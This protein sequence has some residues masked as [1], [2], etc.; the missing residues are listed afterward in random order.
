MAKKKTNQKKHRFKAT[1]M[2]PDNPIQAVGANGS[3]LP[4]TVSALTMV[5]DTNEFAYVKG[6]VVRVGLLVS[7]LA[8]AQ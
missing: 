1:N 4:K 7:A 3:G 8:L 6:D 2:S 5:G